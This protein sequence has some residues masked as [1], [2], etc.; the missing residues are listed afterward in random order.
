M[1]TRRRPRGERPDREAILRV[2]EDCPEELLEL[3]A[4]LLRE[5]VWR[6]REGLAQ[7]GQGAGGATA[8]RLLVRVVRT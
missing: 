5:H 3:R 7:A 2:L 1:T 6:K 8:V 4:T